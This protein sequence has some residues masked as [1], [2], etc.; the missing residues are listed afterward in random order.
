MSR[1]YEHGWSCRK[2]AARFDR[3]SGAVHAKLRQVIPMRPPK[4]HASPGSRHS[5]GYIMWR[6]AYI[7]RIV[8]AGWLERDLLPG[9]SVHHIDG[10]KTNNHPLNLRVCENHREH[11]IEHVRNGT[12][13]KFWTEE[14]D[15]LLISRWASGHTSS[16]IAQEVGVHRNSVGNRI[17][18]LRRKGIDIAR[19]KF[20][21]HPT[22]EVA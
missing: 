15:A 16:D 19:R 22:Q 2:I 10:D 21:N 5:G 18:K 17:N 9:E 4:C 11:M 8:A 14:R 6:G 7:H 3:L 12:I 13:E 20:A 1:L